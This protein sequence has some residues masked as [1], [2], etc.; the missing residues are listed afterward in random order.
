MDQTTLVIVGVVVL[1][2]IVALLVLVGRSRRAPRPVLRPLSIE[3][4]ERYVSRWDQIEAR[5][6]DAPEEAVGEAD[7]LV[8]ALLG[9][10]GH[11]LAENRLPDE[12]RMARRNASRG[13]TEGMRLAMLHYRAVVEEMAPLVGTPEGLG[14][15]RRETA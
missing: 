5:F 15:G 7:A 10:R 1:V 2:V 8:L 13:G 3:G 4:R 14:E 11:P 6:L 9:E 12:L